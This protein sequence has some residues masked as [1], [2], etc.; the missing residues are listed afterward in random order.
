MEAFLL[1][2][3]EEELAL[4]MEER[5][6]SDEEF[7][8]RMQQ[9]KASLIARE[10]EGILPYALSHK[11]NLQIERSPELQTEFENAKA[12]RALLRMSR[13]PARLDALLHSVM[14]E[15]MLRVAFASLAIA[16][17]GFVLVRPIVWNLGPRIGPLKESQSAAANSSQVQPTQTKPQ[18]FFI[19]AGV[20]RGDS[21]TPVLN[22]HGEKQ[23]IELQIEVRDELRSRRT[24]TI[25]R[26]SEQVFHQ[27]TLEVKA[28]GQ[29]HFVAARLLPGTLQ[30]GQYNLWLTEEAPFA[31]SRQLS[32]IT[33]IFN[34]IKV[35]EQGGR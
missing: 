31:P 7:Y 32:G 21:S 5:L 30:S 23:P 34:V 28:Q 20:L 9:S 16:A 24:L 33:Y 18:V 12:S 35:D 17:I 6:F 2:E 14:N 10:I 19:S 27:E 15:P 26:G 29:L 4:A 11:L 22:L 13:R 1:G 3:C 8:E 25:V